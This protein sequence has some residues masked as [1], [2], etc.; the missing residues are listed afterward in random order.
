MK[1]TPNDC[2]VS[3][4]GKDITA[5]SINCMMWWAQD[6][7]KRG[8]LTKW[9]IMSNCTAPD[10]LRVC[11]YSEATILEETRRVDKE[12]DNVTLVNLRVC[13]YSVKLKRQFERKRRRLIKRVITSRIIIFWPLWPLH[14]HHVWVVFTDCSVL[15]FNLRNMPEKY[16]ALTVGPW[17]PFLFCSSWIWQVNWI[18]QLK[19]EEKYL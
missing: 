11:L 2:K 5:T 10:H 3:H 16:I 1:K 17:V 4:F 6:W 12:G 19:A 13:F 15:E 14:Q 18:A 7:R 9:V 8:E